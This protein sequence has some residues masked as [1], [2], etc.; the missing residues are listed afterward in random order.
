ML[1]ANNEK[2]SKKKK[3]KKEPNS[4]SD[5]DSTNQLEK[6]DLVPQKNEHKT[7]NKKIQKKIVKPKTIF[8]VNET[9]HNLTR[10]TRVYKKRQETNNKKVAVFPNSSISSVNMYCISQDVERDVVHLYTVQ[11]F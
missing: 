2:Q 7:K 10:D 11:H 6:E 5:V 3:K 8:L 9:T 1:P 4:I